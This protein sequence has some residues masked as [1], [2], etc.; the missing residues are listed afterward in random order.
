M[1]LARKWVLNVSQ[2]K[3]AVQGTPG[4]V[5]EIRP[6]WGEVERNLSTRK[7]RR[8]FFRGFPTPSLPVCTI[9]KIEN[10]EL[11]TLDRVFSKV[12]TNNDFVD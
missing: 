9:L 3:R 10:L 12:H 5:K 11:K 7:P 2:K 4:Q 6:F 8:I 1:V